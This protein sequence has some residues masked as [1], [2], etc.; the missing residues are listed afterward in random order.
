[1]SLVLAVN[2][3]PTRPDPAI[4]GAPVAGVSTCLTNTGSLVSAS[5][6]PASSVNV[7]STLIRLRTSAGITV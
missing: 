1:M 4:T 6:K 2:V 7:T 3:L 5:A